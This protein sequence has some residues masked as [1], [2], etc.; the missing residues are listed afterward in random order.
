MVVCHALRLV[1]YRWLFMRVYQQT[2]NLKYLNLQSA[3]TARLFWR[4]TSQRSVGLISFNDTLI[5]CLGQCHDSRDQIRSG[6]RL[7]KGS[8]S[9]KYESFL[10]E[11]YLTPDPNL[12]SND[13]TWFPRDCGHLSRFCHPARRTC[14][15]NIARSLLSPLP[16]LCF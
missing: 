9:L 3:D 13:R 15:A 5:S 7:R 10:S 6:L 4:P 1:S 14:R 16:N 2:S 8:I 11:S 12:Q